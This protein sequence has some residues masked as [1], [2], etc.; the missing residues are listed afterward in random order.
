VSRGFKSAVDKTVEEAVTKLGPSRFAATTDLSAK[1]TKKAIA[2]AKAASKGPVSKKQ[3]GSKAQTA[4]KSSSQAIDMKDDPEA[5]LDG[6]LKFN[7]QS[8]KTQPLRDWLLKHFD[9]PYPEDADKLV[10]AE[11]SGMTRAQVGNW[12]INARVRIWRPMVLRLGE[13]IEREATP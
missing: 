11:R 6:E 3:S 7:A 8:V 2:A 10:L 1:E 4:V 5:E 12:F 9:K 13:E